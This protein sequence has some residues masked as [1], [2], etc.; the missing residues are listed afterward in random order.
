VSFSRVYKAFGEARAG[1]QPAARL[2]V[3]GSGADH[4]QVVQCLSAGADEARGGAGAVLDV[5]ALSELPVPLRSSDPWDVLVFVADGA[6]PSEVAPAVNAARKAGMAVVACMHANDDA[7]WPRSAGFADDEIAGCGDRG[8]RKRPR[9]EKRI[10]KAAGGG[11]AALAVQLPA[12]RRAYCDQVILT[13]AKQN[14]VIGTVVIIPGADMPAMTANQIRMVLQIAAAHDEEIGF[15]RAVEI[16]SVVGSAFAFRA[17]AR[18]ALAFV[19]GFGWVIK[20]AIG[21]SATIALGRATVAYFEAGA[22]L[23]VSHMKR[24]RDRVERARTKLPDFV[25]RRMAGR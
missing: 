22:P 17:L 7:T 24:V 13:N 9:L 23:Q 2:C 3:V 16:L 14:G 5:R 19:P 8:G 20:G 6:R 10:I 12:V 21:F 11:A 15:D 18:Q 4:S 25:Q 1:G